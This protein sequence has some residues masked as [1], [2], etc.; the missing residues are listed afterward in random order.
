MVSTYVNALV[1]AGFS[2]DRMVEPAAPVPTFL[3]LRCRR[4]ADYEPSS[5]ASI[6]A[7]ERRAH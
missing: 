1:T 3:L 5:E 4:H 2:I 7:Q 6:N